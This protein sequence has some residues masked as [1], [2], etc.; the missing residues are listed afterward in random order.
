MPGLRRLEAAA[1]PLPGWATPN[2]SPDWIAAQTPREL[3]PDAPLPSLG[4]DGMPQGMRSGWKVTIHP[5][6]IGSALDPNVLAKPL[7]GFAL[8]QTEL[9]MDRLLSEGPM[10]GPFVGAGTAALV[11]H[12]AGTY[13]LT[14]RLERP[15][16]EDADCLVRLAFGRRRVI[17]NYNINM[18]DDIART[19]HPIRFA[20]TPGLYR[21]DAMLGCWHDGREG[22]P[23][24]LTVLLAHPGEAVP[25]PLRPDEVVWPEHHAGE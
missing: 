18:V 6:K 13:A 17:S 19:Y 5:V 4:T 12:V 25:V 8:E 9:D 16:G 10:E 22:G 23:G 14:A 21:I 1:P 7:R 24:R 15:A 3:P 2:R 11:I 20:L